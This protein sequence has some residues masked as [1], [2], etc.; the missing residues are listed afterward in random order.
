LSKFERGEYPNLPYELAEKLA[1]FYGV[2]VSY[3]LGYEVEVPERLKEI[4]VEW[5][6]FAEKMQKEN[7]TAEQ[8]EKYV[9][10]IKKLKESGIVE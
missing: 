3:L 1:D 9:T 8:V 7:I 5:L 10:A 2:P 6:V 4:G